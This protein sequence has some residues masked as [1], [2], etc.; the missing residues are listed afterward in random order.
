MKRICLAVT[1]FLL[2]QPDAHARWA[3]MEDAPYSYD[4]ITEDFEVHADGTYKQTVYHEI[5]INK[6]QGRALKGTTHITYNSRTSKYRLLDAQVKTNGIIFQVD[7]NSIEDK[8]I[9]SRDDGFDQLNQVSIPFPSVEIGSKLYLKYEL[10]FTEV[11]IHQH[12]SAQFRW[13]E[14]APVRSAHVTISSHLPLY[15]ES[16]DSQHRV[17][18]THERNSRHTVTLRLKKPTF[19]K[20]EDEPDSI[21][22]NSDSLAVTV[23][24]DQDFRK[25]AEGVQKRYESVLNSPLPSLMEEIYKS[26][27][28]EPDLVKRF[29]RITAQMADHLR[30]HGDWKAVDGSHIPRPLNVINGTRFGDCKDLAATLT[31]IL[32]KQGLDAHVAWIYRSSGPVST[33]PAIAFDGAFNHAITYVNAKSKIYWLDPTNRQSFAQGIFEDI[34]DRTALILDPINPRLERVPSSSPSDAFRKITRIFDL[35]KK[36]TVS[37][38]AE[39]RFFGRSAVL[40]TGVALDFTSIEAVKELL[41]NSITQRTDVIES[42][43]DISDVLNKRQVSDATLKA[44]VLSKQTSYRTSLGYVWFDDSSDWIK[45]LATHDRIS[46][47][48][49]GAPD[50]VEREVILSGIKLVSGPPVECTIHSRWF[51]ST[52]QIHT[53]EHGITIQDRLETKVSSISLRELKSREFEDSQRSYRNCYDK[54]AII[55]W[56]KDE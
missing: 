18:M 38:Q 52:R 42:R 37:T 31:A 22:D 28:S 47:Y 5:T 13:G 23:S 53:S 21:V 41:L 25:L 32:R 12:F 15:V 1:L 48:W 36:E 46:G 55:Y 27:K 7:K 11:P 16:Q 29:N 6:D 50:I 14:I 26:T 40:L 34:A 49:A 51:S 2:S 56:P 8:P 44:S 30:Y 19:W 3:T 39:F 54:I 10:E 43:I 33:L 24:S 17:E 20:V 4:E 45:T 9:A 35:S